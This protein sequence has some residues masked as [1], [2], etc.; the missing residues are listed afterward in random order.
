MKGCAWMVGVVILSVCSVGFAGDDAIL[1]SYFKNNGETGVFLAYSEDG[2][3]FKTL[4]DGRPVF[5]PPQW[6]GQNLTRDPSIVFHDG[7]FHMVWTTNWEGTCFGA[8]TSPDLKNWSEPVRV[9]PFKNWPADDKPTT[10]WAPEVHWDPV[11]KNYIILWS[12][13]T[14]KLDRSPGCSA[15]G[16]EKVPNLNIELN[17]QH[18]RIFISRTSDF[19]SFTDA[20]VFF[21]PGISAIDACMVFDDRGS[22]NIADGRWVMAIKNEQHGLVG[23]K[24]IRVAV[25]GADLT[26]PF[27]PQFHSPTDPT[28]PWSDP[29]VGPRAK[30][31]PDQ[32]VEGPTLF[33]LGN[34]WRIYFDRYRAAKGRYGMV[35][36]KDLVEWTDRSADVKLPDD[37]HH[38]TVFS[39]PL[40]AVFKALSKP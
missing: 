33:K 26:K 18:H 10:T 4:N 11:Q 5:T 1:F 34:E 36:S 40:T 20:Q 38:G 39:A 37:A 25:A 3:T 15:G 31:Q 9:E 27:P 21:A 14:A 8:S 22:K 32:W 35:S 7:L 23:G 19:K 24:N 29:I 17:I 16:L 30:L 13:A 2:I 28:K 12:T 6:A